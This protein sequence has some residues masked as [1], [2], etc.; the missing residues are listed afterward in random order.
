MSRIA[1]DMDYYEKIC[2]MLGIKSNRSDFYDHMD[3]IKLQILGTK[4]VSDYKLYGAVE[5]YIKFKDV[6]VTIDNL[7]K[8]E[9]KVK[10]EK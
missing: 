3:E 5:D 1:D 4:H 2:A 8:L 6:Q 10:N 9:E 7:D